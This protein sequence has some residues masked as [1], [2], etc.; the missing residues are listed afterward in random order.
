MNSISTNQERKN[1]E[2]LEDD[3]FQPVKVQRTGKMTRLLKLAG[4]ETE[5][6]PISLP[7]P[8]W[9][10]RYTPCKIYVGSRTHRQLA[11]L[12]SELKGNT[13]Y[14]PKMTVLGSRDQMC[15]EKRVSKSSTKNDDC[16]ALMETSSCIPGVNSVKLVRHSSIQKDGSKEIW[17]IEDLVRIGKQIGACPYYAARTIA[18][19]AE[20]IFCP[21]NYIIDPN[22]RKSMGITLQDNVVILDE[23]HN[24]EDVARTSGSFEATETEWNIIHIELTQVIRNFRL[25][26]EHGVIL[27]I[28][29]SFLSWMRD[30]EKELNSKEHGPDIHLLSGPE[31]ISELKKL[32]IT[33]SSF[34]SSITPAFS[35]VVQYTENVRKEKEKEKK[36]KPNDQASSES[37]EKEANSTFS[38]RASISTSSLRLLESFFMVIGF[39]YEPEHTYADDYRMVLIRNTSHDSTHGNDWKYKMGFWCLNPGIIFKQISEHA[40]SVILTSGTLSPLSIFASEL[41]A[42]FANKL[43]AT[44]VVDKSQLWVRVIP[45]GPRGSPLKGVYTTVQTPQYQDDVGEA[46]CNIIE[47]VPFGVLVFLSSYSLLKQ[48]QTSWENKET[49]E[50]ILCG[51][52][53]LVFEKSLNKYYEYINDIEETGPK[54]GID[55]AIFFAVF[56]GKV[57]EGIDFK[58]N[59]C[60]AVISLGIPFPSV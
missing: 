38:L 42:P 6:Q 18:E 47:T 52:S 51:S 54:K 44:H 15:I 14:R 34:S 21:Y 1:V 53:K 36:S 19:E 43:E 32:Q 49:K 20:I 40:H 27:S 39:F 45:Y 37:Q 17:D 28:V 60:R 22:I 13:C 41:E 56:R 10:S 7:L 23:A 58:D 35:K 48:L 24:I 16:K 4:V 9:L 46:L 8:N 31:I 55:G 50:D 57:S 25:H 3:D 2:T 59:H 30:S 12:I 26:I 29:D 33:E 5:Q 11:Q